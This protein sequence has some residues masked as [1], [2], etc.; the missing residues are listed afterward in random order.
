HFTTLFELEN[1]AGNG[2]DEG[3]YYEVGI[4]PGL[5]IGPLAFTFPITA[6]FGSNNFYNK[7]AG[8]GYFSAGAQVAYPL[9]FMPK[10]LGVWTVTGGATYYYLGSNSLRDYNTPS[11]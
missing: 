6:G 10:C 8:F 3:V 5:P 9:A 7:D 1:K 2:P 11:T 4:A